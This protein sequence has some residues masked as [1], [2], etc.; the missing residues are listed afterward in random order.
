MVVHT[1]LDFIQLSPCLYN[2]DLNS[3]HSSHVDTK[4][5]QACQC[6]EKNLYRKKELFD[7]AFYLQHCFTDARMT[8]ILIILLLKGLE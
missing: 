2:G 6:K 7:E 1:I 8:E 3:Y 5:T 4:K